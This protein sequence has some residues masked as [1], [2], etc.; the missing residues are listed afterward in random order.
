MGMCQ[1]T[2]PGHTGIEGNEIADNL[3]KEAASQ[4]RQRDQK[5]SYR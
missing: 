2:I 5:Y 1:K 4:P 3:A